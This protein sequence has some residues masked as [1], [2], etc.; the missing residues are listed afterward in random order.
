MRSALR[1]SLLG[2][3]VAFTSSDKTGKLHQQITFQDACPLNSVLVDGA[4]QLTTHNSL[5]DASSRL[6]HRA[7]ISQT[8]QTIEESR[9]AAHQAA[10]FPWTFWP[11]CF[12]N[13]KTEDPYCVFS[14]QNFANGRGIS[15][16]TT[17]TFAYAMREKPVFTRPQLLEQVNRYA[18]PPFVQHEFPGKGRG[19]VANKTLHRGDVIFSS[20]PI[21]VT[22]SDS[23]A[24]STSERLALYYRAVDT[25]PPKT[26]ASFWA[27]LGHFKDDPVDD[28][29]NTNN[30]DANIDGVPQQVLFPEIAMLNHDC[31]PNAAYFFD[32]E[33]MTH[34]VHAI[35]EIHPGEEITI[36][37][38]D[39]EKDRTT[40]MRR[41]KKNWGF[42]CS[43]STCT[44]HAKI[45][46]ESDSRLY[47][48][49]SL[50]KALDDWTS[51]T[52]ATPEI[53]ELLISLYQ[54][55]RLDASLATAYKYAAEV[56]SSF[57]KKWEAIRYARLSV[58]MSTLDKGFRDGDVNAMKKMIEEPE[59]TWSWMKRVGSSGKGCGCGHAH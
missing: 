8:T 13:E 42:E 18:N 44:A 57:G 28:R 2:G 33:M 10:D 19:L 36:T 20:T 50:A 47:Q 22:D 43:C 40:R 49:T 11:E 29:I 34:Y 16:I 31:R 30:F 56:Y 3:A 14:D 55:E 15:I 26:Q 6:A 59:M 37:Y 9:N 52:P 17:Q 39:N 54:Q 27:L 51:T 48:I 23:Y 1:L 35:K 38:I 58:E 41:L 4:C 24:L 25:L 5:H 21:L 45:V 12:S 46:E 53:A 32:E 7:N